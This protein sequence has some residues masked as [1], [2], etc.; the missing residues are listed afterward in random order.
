[1][2]NVWKIEKLWGSFDGYTI[3]RFNP[4]VKHFSIGLVIADIMDAIKI[5]EEL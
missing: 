2:L 4:N 3:V 1:M 5:K